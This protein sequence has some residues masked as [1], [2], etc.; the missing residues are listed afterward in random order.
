MKNIKNDFNGINLASIKILQEKLASILNKYNLDNGDIYEYAI[1]HK[2]MNKFKNL[3]F[4]DLDSLMKKDFPQLCEFNLDLKSLMDYPSDFKLITDDK[5]TLDE[6]RTYLKSELS[7]LILNHNKNLIIPS[8][9]D[10]PEEKAKMI[11][12][13]SYNTPIKDNTIITP[14]TGTGLGQDQAVAL[15]KYNEW[16]IASSYLLTEY[17]IWKKV[18]YYLENKNHGSIS[19]EFKQ[20]YDQYI[21]RQF[22][23]VLNLE[24]GNM[25]ENIYI[26]DF[27]LNDVI[28]RELY[29]DILYIL[30]NLLLAN[31]IIGNISLENSLNNNNKFFDILKDI[32]KDHYADPVNKDGYSCLKNLRWYKVNNYYTEYHIKDIDKNVTAEAKPLV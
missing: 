15:I 12:W 29:E 26:L 3:N 5:I 16:I 22:T 30:L 8:P 19:I 21:Y 25:D 9:K 23:S 4:K 11:D 17:N 27:T 18:L 1:L 28:T 20:A 2:N 14:M 24:P 32:I 6:D 13:L 31:K 7:N 10:F